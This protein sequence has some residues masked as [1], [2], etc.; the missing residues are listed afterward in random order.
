MIEFKRDGAGGSIIYLAYFMSNF[1]HRAAERFIPNPKLKFME[2][3][4]EI[5]R[6]KHFSLRAE[7]AYLHWIK[8]FIFFH[9]KRHPKEMGAPEMNRFLSDLAT[10]QHVA[11]STQNQALF[12]PKGQCYSA[13]GCEQCELPWGT[14]Q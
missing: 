13:Q 2:Q 7:E 6:F 4:R 5:M 9:E 12:A 10:R 1:S 8:R 11:A 3:C 14:G